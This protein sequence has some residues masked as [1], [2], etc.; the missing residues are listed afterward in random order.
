MAKSTLIE[1]IKT[2]TQPINP[3]RFNHATKL[4]SIPDIKCVA[5]DFYGT[6][7]ISGVGDI[8]VDEISR[9]VDRAVDMTFGCQMHHR[10]RLMN[11]KDS[12]EGCTVAC[13]LHYSVFDLRDGRIVRGPAHHPQPVLP[14][15]VRNGWIEVRG[16]A[17][18]S[19]RSSS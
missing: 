19:R 10:I 14:A 8:G 5:F 4:K 18:R 7:F 1:R 16:S 2:L 6:M 3:K 17:P 12:V 15:R 9:P 13:P 11:R